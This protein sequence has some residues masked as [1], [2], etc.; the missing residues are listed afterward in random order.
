MKKL[1]FFLLLLFLFIP[2]SFSQ[3]EDINTNNNVRFGIR[4]G[5]NY[6]RLNF[7]LASIPMENPPETSWQVGAVGGFY[8]VVP[9]YKNLY[10]QPEYLYSRAG[11]K[12]EVDYIEYDLSYL[13]LPVYLRW[14]LTNRFS[15]IAGPQFDILI[16]SHI[17]EGNSNSAEITHFTEAR[18]IGYS[19]GA[20]I[21]I[22]NSLGISLR[23]FHGAHD[24]WI[25]VSENERQEFKHQRFQLSLFYLF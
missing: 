15:L 18:S 8:M 12:A 14:E 2:L 24:I 3:E 19:G 1:F 11:G 9:L 22:S 7:S 10:I 20:E 4:A 6:S 23:Y 17:E 25:P 21:G 13:S 5:I 16:N